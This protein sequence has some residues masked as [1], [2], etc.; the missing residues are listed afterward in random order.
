[1]RSQSTLTLFA[2]TVV[3]GVLAAAL[4]VRHTAKPIDA[5]RL[6]SEQRWAREHPHA[7][8]HAQKASANANSAS[9]I[10]TGA[11][12]GTR[13]RLRMMVASRRALREIYAPVSF[14]GVVNRLF[15]KKPA[16]Y[17]FRPEVYESKAGLA[18]RKAKVHRAK[19]GVSRLDEDDAEEAPA[20]AAPAE[21]APAEAAP[22]EAAP[23]EEAPVVVDPLD[24][25]YPEGWDDDYDNQEVRLWSDKPPG[26]DDDE[27][28]DVEIMDIIMYDLPMFIFFM[29]LLLYIE[30]TACL[31]RRGRDFLLAT[32]AWRGNDEAFKT[33]CAKESQTMIYRP[34]IS[35][36]AVIGLW[37]VVKDSID[38]YGKCFFNFECWGNLDCHA[39]ILLPAEAEC[40]F[41]I[42]LPA[43]VVTGVL[44]CGVL[45]AVWGFTRPW[46]SVVLIGTFFTGIFAI[47]TVSLFACTLWVLCAVGFNY[48]YFCMLP[49]IEDSPVWCED[50]GSLAFAT[51]PR[52][53]AVRDGDK[54][55]HWKEDPD[56]T[57]QPTKSELETLHWVERFAYHVSDFNHTHLR[58]LRVI[59]N[60]V[61]VRGL[62]LGM[63]GRRTRVFGEE[64]IKHL[65][66]H[67]K[68][69][70]ASNHRTFFDFWV[71]TV[72]GLWAKGGVSLFSFYPVRSTWVY[73]NFGGM[74][75][76]MSF[77]SYAMF[78]PLMNTPSDKKN[79][80]MRTVDDA[81]KWNDYAI[82]RVI[83]D[84]KSPGVLCG[85]HPEVRTP[86][87]KGKSKPKPGDRVH[88]VAERIGC[89]QHAGRNRLQET[90]C[91]QLIWKQSKQKLQEIECVQLSSMRIVGAGMKIVDT[92][93]ITT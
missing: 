16:A 47:W 69:L 65:G 18:L 24:E 11:A 15:S 67:D 87:R 70:I 66:S 83:S 10:G 53:G 45:A 91:I 85:I 92:G 48:F 51:N 12:A 26:S 31:W 73:T 63:V 32:A 52:T 71:I 72:C 61:F 59:W 50:L 20:E 2:A 82:R 42:M 37:L 5:S 8:S 76:N 46:A 19:L 41:D 28:G 25:E 57:L 88:R 34:Y 60:G 64:H 44:I 27:A 33:Q 35:W 75:M 78:P 40:V 29:A 43:A 79:E 7:H 23:A 49:Y 77:S 6:V 81:H 38:I 68:V 22:A 39:R 89:T 56:G 4:L 62:V 13:G 30:V 90:G 3:L 80:E 9:V 93:G 55:Q 36:F 21:A 17:D 54:A 74:F 86:T 84:L 14:S 58:G 1:M